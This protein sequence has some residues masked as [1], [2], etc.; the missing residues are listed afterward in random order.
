MEAATECNN[1]TSIA[2]ILEDGDEEYI[3][4]ISTLLGPEYRLPRSGVIR[5]GIMKPKNSCTDQD[6]ARYEAMLEEGATWDEIDRALGVDGKGKSKL[7]PAN[8][9]YFSIRPR[10]CLNPAHEKEIHRLY[11]DEDGKLR[12]LP[13]MFP[14]NEWW[15]II[16]HSLRCFGQSGIRFKSK[17]KEVHIN[18]QIDAVRVCQYPME[19]AGKVFG[20]RKWG[21]RPCDPDTCREYQSG[22]C[23]FGGTL[24]FY[25]PG[26]SGIGVWV[27][28]TTSWYSLVNI[29]STLEFVAGITKGQ[30]ARLFYEKKPLFILQKVYRD[31]SVV[32]PKTGKAARREQWLIHLDIPVDMTSL[33]LYYQEQEILK[34][35]Q[36]ATATLGR[37][38][39]CNQPSLSGP[40]PSLPEPTS[41]LPEPASKK[42]A[43]DVVKEYADEAK[44]VMKSPEEEMRERQKADPQCQARMQQKRDVIRAEAT[45]LANQEKLELKRKFD[46][47]I[48][49]ALDE[50]DLDRYMATL[51]EMLVQKENQGALM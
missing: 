9:D 18:N 12:R 34:R 49:D 40:L 17:F 15:K 7:I 32:D 21:E 48:I 47:R 19:E 43:A 29:K 51:Q 23:K 41:T 2:R 36:V 4:A 45:K 38:N 24:S 6:K 20:G 39:G 11:G 16:D 1:T 8:V 46:N 37:G 33:V 14:V 5:P 42:I 25:I 50:A 44:K 22:D 3:A 28:P 35:S 30:L 10:D 26:I 31:I 27:L 13:V